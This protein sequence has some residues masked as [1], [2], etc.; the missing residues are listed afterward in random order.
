MLGSHSLGGVQRSSIKRHLIN[1][2]NVAG[3][4]GHPQPLRLVLVPPVLEELLEQRC[5]AF[6]GQ[7]LD[8]KQGKWPVRGT[9]A[10]CLAGLWFQLLSTTSL[11]DVGPKEGG[12]NPWS[13]STEVVPPNHKKWYCRQQ[14]NVTLQTC[15]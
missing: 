4:I 15:T 7:D 2:G 8:L 12:K 14:R 5:F 13:P 1:V 10:L 9:L 3:D 11:V 6:L